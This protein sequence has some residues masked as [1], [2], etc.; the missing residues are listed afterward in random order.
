[1]THKR[2]YVLSILIMMLIMTIVIYFA[3]FHTSEQVYEGTLIE[4]EINNWRC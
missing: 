1:M 3:F 4:N 2:T